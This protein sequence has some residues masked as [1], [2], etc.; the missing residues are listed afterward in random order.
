[1]LAR[2]TYGTHDWR[3]GFSL[4]PQE[5]QA[6]YEALAHRNFS[7]QSLAEIDTRIR[8]MD[9]HE[10]GSQWDTRRL[11]TFVQNA[12]EYVDHAEWVDGP[13]RRL[14]TA[15]RSQVPTARFRLWFV[16]ASLVA[17]LTIDRLPIQPEELLFLAG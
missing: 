14:Q 2:L 11:A 1:M 5:A 3:R 15:M 13:L 12:R 7:S 6:L 17:F 10:P 9:P 4:L 8:S 16:R